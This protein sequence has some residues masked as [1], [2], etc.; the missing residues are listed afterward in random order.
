MDISDAVLES[1]TKL[2]SSGKVEE[3]VDQALGKCVA[4]V[5]SD[6]LDRYSPF[7][8]HLEEQ[9]RKALAVHGDID[10]P[11]YN[12]VILKIVRAQI[13]TRTK[14]SIESAV[15]EQLKELLTPAPETIKL[16]ELAAK[17]LEMVKEKQ[18]GG[19]VCYGEE[20]GIT[21]IVEASDMHL[22]SDYHHI[23]LDESTNKSKRDCAIDIGISGK[24][25]I[26]WLAFKN[27]DVEKRMFAG[28]F[29]GFERMLF[30]MKAAGTKLVI[31][32]DVSDIET[33]F[34]LEHSM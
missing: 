16:S 6:E 13:E 5:I 33:R 19:C 2:V 22:T 23:Y 11:S 3:A 25:S 18:E 10:L 28:P 29:Y 7:G 4:R 27:Q 21:V 15:A 20:H 26:Y 30:Q 31:D 14:A 8:K 34:G 32:C 9:V 24:G 12:D 1:L 17:Y